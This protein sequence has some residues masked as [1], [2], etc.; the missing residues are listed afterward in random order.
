MNSSKII[1]H[2]DMNCFFA[3]CEV[4]QNDELLGKP[5]AIAHNDPLK[6]GIIVSPSY[7]ARK[8][9]I[10][11]TM[12]VKEA[13][14]LCNELIVIEPD[15]GLYQHYSKL[16][17]DYLFSITPNVEIASIDEGYLDVTDVCNK[18]HPLDLANKIQKHLQEEYRL[19]TS[20]GISP[21]KFLSKMA[22]NMKKPLGITVLRKREIDKYLWPL[23]ISK[24][25]GVGKKTTPR[26]QS[27]NIN[28][29]GDLAN[30]Q[31]IELL[32]ETVGE[33]NASSL[34]R[35]ANGIDNSTVDVNSFSE[36]S[37]VS[38]SHTFDNDIYDPSYIKKTLKIISNTVSHRLKKSNNKAQTIGIQLKFNN[39]KQ[40]NRSKGL[41]YPINDE[42]QIYDIA[43]DLFDDFFKQGDQIRLV[44]I[45]ANRL[46]EDKE[47]IKQYSIFDDLSSLDKEEGIQKILSNLQNKYGKNSINRG[48]F[49]FKKKEEIK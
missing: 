14:L 19:P 37:S 44:G 25:H 49:E 42:F 18:I 41:E 31:D 20:I 26:L 36:A 34:V 29:I 17:F 47:E 46:V 32:K 21:N 30:F 15:M 33:V 12:K 28:S 3:S 4:A 43:E 8:F 11:T 22:S 7:E 39:F 1:F 13:L 2:I 6:R 38:N 40:M 45:F 48:Y 35:R 24:M 23:D 10:K 16:F 5:I 9:G 27:I